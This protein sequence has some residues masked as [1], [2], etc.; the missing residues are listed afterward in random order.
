MNDQRTLTG[1]PLTGIWLHKSQTKEMST[2][3]GMLSVLLSVDY[4]RRYRFHAFLS[5]P[6]GK[7]AKYDLKPGAIIGGSWANYSL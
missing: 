2:A 6:T 5:T 1:L 4:K 3:I 7:L